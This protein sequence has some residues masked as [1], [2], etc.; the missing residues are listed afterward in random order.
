MAAP[1][2]KKACNAGD[3]KGVDTPAAGDEE[4]SCE[5]PE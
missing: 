1:D 3:G 5:F 2:G 4:V